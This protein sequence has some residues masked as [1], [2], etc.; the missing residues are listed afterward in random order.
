MTL[1]EMGGKVWGCV[2]VHVYMQASD[3][4]TQRLNMMKTVCA[5]VYLCACV[6]V[7]VC[8][9]VCARAFVCVYACVCVCVCV[10]VRARSHQHA[11]A[12]THDEQASGQWLDNT[13]LL[14]TRLDDLSRPALRNAWDSIRSHL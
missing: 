4:E 6:C 14:W 13:K 8:V 9:C 5:C 1:T 11:R 2:C 12:H 3:W 7:C 10:R